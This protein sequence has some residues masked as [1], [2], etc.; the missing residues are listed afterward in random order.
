MEKGG[1]ECTKGETLS[2]T[3]NED[4]TFQ[5]TSTFRRILMRQQPCVVVFFPLPINIFL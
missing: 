4:L 2:Q 3:R 5:D 1:E